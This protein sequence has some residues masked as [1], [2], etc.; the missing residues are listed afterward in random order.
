[1]SESGHSK[2]SD[3]RPLDKPLAKLLD[4][5]TPDPAATAQI[6]RRR[7]LFQ[8]VIVTFVLISAWIAVMVGLQFWST[9]GYNFQTETERILSL[10]RDGKAELVYRDA[11]PRFQQM[12]IVDR[13]LDS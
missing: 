12:I 1:M 3:S 11:S 9:G 5:S 6:R 13:F 4:R 8:G 7:K 10:M 2:K